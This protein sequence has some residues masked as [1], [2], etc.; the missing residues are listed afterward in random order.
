MKVFRCV[1]TVDVVGIYILPLIGY[2]KMPKYQSFWVGWLWWL[3][4]LRWTEKPEKG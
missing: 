2:S 4:E 1:F 3:W